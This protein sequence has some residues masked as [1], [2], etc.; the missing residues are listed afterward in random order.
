MRGAGQIAELAR[1]AEPDV[2][3]ITNIG[4]VH[5]ELLG[6]VEAIAAVK[7]E[8]LA[9]LP[10]S[11]TAVIPV[12]EPLLEEHLEGVPRVIRFGDDGDVRTA[13]VT[14]RGESTEAL[15]VTPAGE[16]LFTFPFAEQHNVTNALA[17]IGAG[18]AL[19][20][21]PGA[22]APGAADI[23]FS[24]FRGE[25]LSLGDRITLVNDCYNA[26]PVSMRAALDNL[27]EAEGG[28]RI[29]VL[30]VM[31]ELGPEGPAFHEGSASM[32][33]TSASTR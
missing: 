4:P 31:A 1:I 20:F 12:D 10:E 3:V 17:A 16:H 9:H 13:S 33:A 19:G 30:G 22:L 5:V 2:G 32:R 23:G 28:R 26:N 25:R 18:V 15:V 27:A 21:E 29:A 14:R 8:L 6:S 11:G 24:R 7:A